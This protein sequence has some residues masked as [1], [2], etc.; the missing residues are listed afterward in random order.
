MTRCYTI[1]GT[2]VDVFACQRG[3]PASLRRAQLVEAGQQINN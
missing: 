2:G 1:G 3:G